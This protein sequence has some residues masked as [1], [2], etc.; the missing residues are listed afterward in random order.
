MIKRN[1]LHSF[2]LQQLHLDCSKRLQVFRRHQ[3]SDSFYVKAKIKNSHKLEPE[4]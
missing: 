4:N 2:G 1:V 3:H